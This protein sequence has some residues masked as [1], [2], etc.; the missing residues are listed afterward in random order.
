MLC[1]G[2]ALSPASVGAARP[3]NTATTPRGASLCPQGQNLGVKGV[4]QDWCNHRGIKCVSTRHPPA[5]HRAQCCQH[6]PGGLRALPTSDS[7]AGKALCWDHCC[8]PHSLGVGEPPFPAGK[9]QIWLPPAQPCPLARAARTGLPKLRA[10]QGKGWAEPPLIPPRGDLGSPCSV[11]GG[12]D[13][14]L[15]PGRARWP[16]QCWCPTPHI[17]QM[18]QI[19]EREEEEEEK[20]EEQQLPVTG[21]A[22]LAHPEQDVPVSHPRGLPGVLVPL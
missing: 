9:A 16:L 11:L 1:A 12:C 19:A 10:W 13:L 5:Q 14:S 15:S 17:S 7:L 6:S 3:Q 21:L 2:W 20:E 4:I 22:T 18:Q 8:F